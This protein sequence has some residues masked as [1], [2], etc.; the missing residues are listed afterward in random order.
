[1]KKSQILT[2]LLVA[3]APL[4]QAGSFRVAPVRIDLTARQPY[5]TLQVT[6]AGT[7]RVT[8]QVDAYAWRIEDGQ[9]RY[10]DTDDILINPPIFTF[11][12]GA[13]QLLRVGIRQRDSNGADRTK[14]EPPV[15]RRHGAREAGPGEVERTYR[16][17]LE[18]VPSAT[19]AMGMGIQTLLRMSIPLFVPGSADANPE[20]VWSAA[21]RPDGKLLL[22]VENRGNQHVQLR[23]LSVQVG[24][25]AK[26]DFVLPAP[27]YVLP[28]TRRDWIV[29]GTAGARLQIDGQTDKGNLHE[30][31]VVAH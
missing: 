11:E 31:A 3:A 27:S 21:K 10:V 30:T 5:G 26:P 20:L 19:R 1:M 23:Q 29:T 4:L 18:E 25:S 8:V 13:T 7:E 17:V 15:P 14:S 22:S 2:L 24:E 12:P 28:G 6:N 16:I 9:D